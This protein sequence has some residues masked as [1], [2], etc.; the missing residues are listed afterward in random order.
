[1]NCGKNIGWC[2]GNFEGEL[3][4]F[5]VVTADV[6]NAEAVS[7]F[8]A[9]LHRLEGGQNINQDVLESINRQLDT[10]FVPSASALA[11]R[12]SEFVSVVDE[13]ISPWDNW[14][15]PS[16]LAQQEWRKL[17]P[18]AKGILRRYTPQ[19][20]L[21]GENLALTQDGGIYLSD[22]QLAFCS[23]DTKLAIPWENIQTLEP[24]VDLKRLAPERPAKFRMVYC[25]VTL[26]D[27]AEEV[28][29]HLVSAD[30]AYEMAHMLEYFRYLGENSQ[31]PSARRHL[32]IGAMSSILPKRTELLQPLD[33]QPIEADFDK[34]L[35]LFT[36]SDVWDLYT[37]Y[38]SA[39][40]HTELKWQDEQSAVGD[41][42]THGGAG[43][44]VSGTTKGVV[45]Q[46][47]MRVPIPKTLFTP[48]SADCEV[49]LHRILTSTSVA[50]EASTIT[51]GVP[52]SDCFSVKERVE[53]SKIGT[54]CLCKRL[55][56]IY[57]MKSTWLESIVTSSTKASCRKASPIFV[58]TVMSRCR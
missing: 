49:I 36:S 47:N 7:S 4:E 32:S 37:D 18:Q 38:F 28:I 12:P 34:V 24:Y 27:D 1:M 20:R 10:L 8:R 46:L 25:P 52:A 53:I 55:I 39:L 19:V 43:G 5:R 9:I 42:P 41:R 22:D 31:T 44:L 11:H 35:S 26:I 16:K 14:E 48:D 50:M 45:R 54:G 58:K 6:E 23:S 2:V 57:W 33:E 21:H 29:I 56:G 51:L 15:S 40:G 3:G 30:K 13:S 17:W